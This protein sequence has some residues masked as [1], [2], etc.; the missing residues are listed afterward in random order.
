M[1][2]TDKLKGL[3]KEKRITQSQLAEK[4]GLKACTV[5]QKLN[6][7]RDMSLD[8][9]EAIADVLGIEAI[10]FGKYFFSHTVA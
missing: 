10:D 8:E 9:A 5:N 4:L 2:N 3:M 1:I 6:G 7:K